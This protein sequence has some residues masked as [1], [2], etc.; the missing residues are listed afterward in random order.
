ML[1]SR[2]AAKLTEEMFIYAYSDIL[3]FSN[4]SQAL[5]TKSINMMVNIVSP[6]P[7][8]KKI[9]HILTFLIASTVIS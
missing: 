8:K 7:K 9:N 4:N 1:A 6:L 2:E 3:K 5:N